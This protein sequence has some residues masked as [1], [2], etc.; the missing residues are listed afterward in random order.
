MCRPRLIADH[1][2]GKKVSLVFRQKFY[3][4][5]ACGA[6]FQFNNHDL[7]E[8]VEW[9]PISSQKRTELFMIVAYLCVCQSK[10]LDHLRYKS[11]KFQYIPDF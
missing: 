4:N 1:V 11:N 8:N 10:E 5:L 3:Q 6:Y 9:N 2:F 7:F